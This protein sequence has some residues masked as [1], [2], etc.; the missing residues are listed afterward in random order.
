MVFF[1]AIQS[2]FHI[3]SWCFNVVYI[4]VLDEGHQIPVFL[5]EWKRAL[6]T[7]IVC[8]KDCK[9]RLLINS[10]KQILSQPFSIFLVQSW[11]RMDCVWCLHCLLRRNQQCR[12]LSSL[13]SFSNQAQCWPRWYLWSHLGQAATVLAYWQLRYSKLVHLAWVWLV[14]WVVSCFE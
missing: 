8:K 13:S 1:I 10:L 11:R 9:I 5:L 2:K 6:A 7:T 4:G 14:L 3:Q 12:K